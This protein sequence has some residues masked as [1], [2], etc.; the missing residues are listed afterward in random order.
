MARRNSSDACCSTRE[1]SRL[2]GVKR[3]D[4]DRLFIAI[5]DETLL[6]RSVRIAK[7]GKFFLAA[8]PQRTTE[9]TH[10]RS[11]QRT[12]IHIAASYRFGFRP[13]STLR[14]TLRRLA[15]GRSAGTR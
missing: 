10:W 4:I 1:L 15:R 3:A 6:G 12:L 11:G 7:L 14:A 13:A 9:T 5:L 8:T 2:S